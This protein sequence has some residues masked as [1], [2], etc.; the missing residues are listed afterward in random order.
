MENE[1]T[2]STQLSPE[3]LAAIEQIVDKVVRL[4]QAEKLQA[5][6]LSPA[7]VCKLFQPAISRPT[8][9]KWTDDGLIPVQK[10]GGRV[11]YKYSDVIEAGSKLKRYKAG[12]G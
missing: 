2:I 12:K 11:W 5:Q 1:I 6:L 3:S 7:E 8:L 9:I 4:R 10:I